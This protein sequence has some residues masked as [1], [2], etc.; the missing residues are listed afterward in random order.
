MSG[1]AAI[2]GALSFTG[3]YLTTHL[4]DNGLVSSIINLSSR[5]QPISSHNLSPNHL[6]KITSVP[7]TFHDPTSLSKSLENVDVLYCTY[8]IRY[9]HDGDTHMK[10]AE[11]CHILFQCAQNAGVKKV[12]FSAHT[13]L[14]LDSPYEYIAGKAKAVQ[15]LRDVSNSSSS[16]PSGSNP[17]HKKMNYAVVKPC[18]IFGDKASESILFNNAAY[19]LRRTPLFLLPNNGMARF[20]PIYVKD[21][22]KLMCNLGDESI[23]TTGEELDA[24]GPDS[25]TALQLFRSLRDATSK[26]SFVLPSYLPP[27]LIHLATKPLDWM[28]G[29]TLLDADDLNL[30]YSGL[31]IAD[32]P[33]DPRICDRKSV[34]E[35]FQEKGDELG[36]EYVN[37]MERY[38][39]PRK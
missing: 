15:Y 27:R 18:G 23:H 22:A 37:S 20:Q 19:V 9:A 21:M 25:P 10:A 14:S 7:L 5:K 13:G 33:N 30:M 4:L 12:V 34:L 32:D 11:R 29:D 26:H 39:Y 24:V 1:T 38:Y 31:T 3:R 16:D 2:T 8:W 36:R 35:W 28:T 6:E 17:N